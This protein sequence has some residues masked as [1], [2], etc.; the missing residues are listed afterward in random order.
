MHEFLEGTDSSNENA[1]AHMLSPDRLLGRI[2][3]RVVPERVRRSYVAKFALVMGLILGVTVV[4]AVFFYVDITGQIEADTQDDLR[5]NAINDA[6]V[7][8]GWVREHERNAEM[9]SRTDA[10]TGGAGEEVE[11]ALHAHLDVLS[12]EVHAVHYVDRQSDEVVY[13]TDPGATD[14]DVAALALDVHLRGIGVEEVAWDEVGN[15][16]LGTTYSDVYERDGEHL[17]AFF[18]PVGDGTDVVMV[19]VDVT[20]IGHLFSNPIAGSYT[21]V[22]DAADR[23]VILS[24]DEDAIDSQ[25]R[26]GMESTAVADGLETGTGTTEY[27][28]TDEVVGYATVGETDW[29]LVAHA[30]RDSAYALADSVAVSLIALIVIVLSGFLAL[31]ATMGRSTARALG[32]VS[33][34]ALALSRGDTDLE[35]EHEDRID[36]VGQVRHS[37]EEIRGYVE[38]ATVQADAIARQEFDDPVLEEEVPGELGAS[39][40]TMRAELEEYIDELE[41]SR[42]EAARA[43]QDAEALAG[44][45]ERTAAE[46]GETMAKAADGDLTRRLSEDVDN[47][48]LSEIATAFNTMAGTLEGAV[49]D[50]Q[51]LASEVDE[52]SGDVTERVREVEGVTDEVSRSAEKIATATVEGNERFQEARGEMR[53]LSATVEEIAATADTVADVSDRAAGRADVAGDAAE[54]VRDEMERLEERMDGIEPRSN[55]WTTR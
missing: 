22:V 26:N 13:S 17:V 6:D 12:S 37:F 29:V 15:W 8:T 27:D 11:P 47:D 20:G 28:D 41:A 21:E 53:G 40:G 23:S 51:R 43:R 54:T 34:N 50:I 35:I 19:E 18:A 30:P 4:A 14:V 2:P 46:F 9:L 32:T 16:N 33:E 42:Q 39:L 52:V 10:V 3:A 25:Y 31:G 49:A 36:E 24:P 38:T 48:A 5:V 7:V 45:L 44:R 1:E 55:S